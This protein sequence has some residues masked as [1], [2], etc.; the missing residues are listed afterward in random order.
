MGDIKSFNEKIVHRLGIFQDAISAFSRELRLVEAV[1][2]I[3]D[4]E[5]VE[6]ELFLNSLEHGFSAGDVFSVGVEVD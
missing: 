2:R 6:L 4:A 1:A 5:D 3:L